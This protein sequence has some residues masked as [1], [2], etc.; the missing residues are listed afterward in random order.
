M[1]YFQQL[2]QKRLEKQ[3]GKETT[4]SDNK[5]LQNKLDTKLS[6][7]KGSEGGDKEQLLQQLEHKNK[8]FQDK[9]AHTVTNGRVEKSSDPCIA[10]PCLNGATCLRKRNKH[11]PF[12]CK[13]PLGYKGTLCNTVLSQCESQ[14]CN[15]GHCVATDDGFV[16]NCNPGF[17]GTLCEIKPSMPNATVIVITKE[18][19]FDGEVVGVLFIVFLVILVI[20]FYRVKRRREHMAKQ[21]YEMLNK[22]DVP[23]PLPPGVI[24]VSNLLCNEFFCRC[25]K[26]S[27][28]VEAYVKASKTKIEETSL[29]GTYWIVL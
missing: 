25:T 6:D 10:K 12:S 22:S 29:N 24:E 8:N 27:E 19:V 3:K 15:G 2:L 17:T 26:Q 28:A 16:C 21:Y 18:E 13:C 23:P 11:P 4:E 1:Y 5:L 14:P 9:E 7:R 20:H